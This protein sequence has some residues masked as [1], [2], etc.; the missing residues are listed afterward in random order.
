MRKVIYLL[1]IILLAIA[2]LT[3]HLY[4]VIPTLIV[5]ISIIISLILSDAINASGIDMKIFKKN[6]EDFKILDETMLTDSRCPEIIMTGFLGTKFIIPKFLIEEFR[7][8]TTSDDENTRNEARKAL[9]IVS[10]LRENENL[11]IEIVSTKQKEQDK[12]QS[13][14][15]IAK[16]TSS[17]VVTYDYSITKLGI[18]NGVKVLNIN[19]LQ[20]SL[21]QA[22]LPGDEFTVFVMKEG[23]DK[24]QGV[25]YLEDGTMVVVDN[26]S[27]YIG[28]KVNVVVQSVLKNSNSKIIFTKVK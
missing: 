13:I 17:Q 8:N 15:D 3:Y 22:F 21:K 11:R 26:G 20:I 18:I 7:K 19:D 5:I 4:G 24:N 10:R 12:K 14:I 27:S 1:G 16:E 28:R 2:L 9:D 6:K 23:K 25:G